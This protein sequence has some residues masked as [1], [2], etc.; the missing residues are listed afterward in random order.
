MAKLK[1]F[2]EFMAQRESSAFTRTRKQALLGLGPD[3]PD[4]SLHSRSTAPPGLVDYAEKRKKGKKKKKKKKV[5]EAVKVTRPVNRQIDSWLD[6]VDKLKKDMDELGPEDEMGSDDELGQD[7]EDDV[8]DLEDDVDD[9]E[10]DIDDAE[11][12]AEIDDDEDEDEDDLEGQ[13]P[14]PPAVPQPR[15][16]QTWLKTKDKTPPIDV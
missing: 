13:G 2:K 12:D 16:F 9:L 4:A 8:D 10:D 7:V 14:P 1:T 6:S 5:E 11:D 3:I 15:T